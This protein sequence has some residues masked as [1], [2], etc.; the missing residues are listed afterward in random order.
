MT[1]KHRQWLFGYL[2]IGLWILGFVV[3]TLV[4]VGQSLYYSLT[5]Y[6]VTSEGLE[7][8]YIGFKNYIDIIIKDVYYLEALFNYFSNLTVMLVAIIVFAIIIAMLLNKKFF[9]RGFWRTVYFLPVIISSGPVLKKLTQNGSLATGGEE[10][11]GLLSVLTNAIPIVFS[12]MIG[13]IFEKIVII[14][15]FTGVPVLLFLAGLQ[16]IN[17]HLYEAAKVDG[18]S[19]WE[20]F[21]KIILPDL[22]PLININIIFIVV[23]LSIFSSNEVM[24][25]IDQK[26]L[27]KFGYSNAMTWLY[28]IITTLFLGLYLLIINGSS[29]RRK[30]KKI[31]YMKNN[32][33]E[34][35][36]EES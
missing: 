23:S 15:W 30:N 10:V 19:N 8:S 4:P 18:A 28:F 21:W 13:T 36:K 5:S 7:G 2:F 26:K 22:K 20:I 24:Y 3:F 14:L 35:R 1:K 9:L 25:L 11:G 29:L 16:K 27:I 34:I 31:I 33:V 17:P 12:E 32:M 6:K